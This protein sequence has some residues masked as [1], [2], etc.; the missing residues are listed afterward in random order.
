RTGIW[1]AGG[2]ALLGL[3]AAVAVWLAGGV[4]LRAPDIPP[5]MA[6]ERPAIPSSRVGT[7]AREARR[8]RR[9]RAYVR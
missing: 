9:G 5:W 4:R 1:I 3:V 8:R 2:I 6:G 7:A